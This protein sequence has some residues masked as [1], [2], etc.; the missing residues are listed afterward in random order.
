MQHQGR[1][2]G[3]NLGSPALVPH[4]NPKPLPLL[5]RLSCPALVPHATSAR[6]QRAIITSLSDTF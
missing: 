4:G 1:G 3:V 6:L 2:G 5:P